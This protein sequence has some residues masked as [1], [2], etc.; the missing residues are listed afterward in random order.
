MQPTLWCNGALLESAQSHA[1]AADRG[2]QYGDGHFT[3]VLV[4][5]RQ[6]LFWS[7]H[8]ARLA[9]ASQRLGLQSPDPDQLTDQLNAAIAHAYQQWSAEL[10]P[11]VE[12]D[13]ARLLAKIMVT[14]AGVSQGYERQTDTIQV[15]FKLQLLAPETL[16]D[17]PL[18]LA[19]A[20]LQL[21]HQ[22]QLAGL[23]TLNRLEQVLLAKERRWRGVDELVVCDQY[24]QVCEAISS[25]IFWYD[26]Q[27]WFTPALESCG[28][29]G[30]AR[31]ALIDSGGLGEVQVGQFDVSALLQADSV[32]LCNSVR[33]IRA[34]GQIGTQRFAGEQNMQQIRELL[35]R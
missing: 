29:A 14:S 21:S 13:A 17:T 11:P 31:A 3:T 15:W 4:R 1:L 8:L 32:F 5:H 35:W 22:P 28:I 20:D 9:Q 2:L 6:P 10:E 30:V 19:I 24:G 18:Q 25:N 16:T 12:A 34:V 33:G 26:G 7:Y 23:K 27:Q